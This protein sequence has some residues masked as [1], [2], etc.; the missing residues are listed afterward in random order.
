MGTGSSLVVR[1]EHFLN[2]VVEATHEMAT[3]YKLNLAFY[4]AL[5]SDGWGLLERTRACIPPEIITIADAK[6]GDIGNSARFY[7]DSL[8]GQLDFD[9]IT[10]SPYMGKDSILPFLQF[11]GKGVFLLVRTSNPGGNDFQS[12][13][14]EGQPLYM[15]VAT[16][17]N[18]WA[19]DC[20]GDVGFVMGAPDTDALSSVRGRFPG[21]PFLIPGVGAQ[22]GDPASILRACSGGPFL[23][24]SSRGILYA[25]SGSDYADRARDA[26][27]LLRDTLQNVKPQEAPFL[28]AD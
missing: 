6:R 12:L 15:H 23:V 11:P 1:I 13:S 10:V 5:G 26:A 7:A 22:G 17:G 27:R 25:G 21:V 16:K 20:P 8:L 9:A 19:E 18:D 4:E 3:A 28:D 2:Q 24:N 14:V